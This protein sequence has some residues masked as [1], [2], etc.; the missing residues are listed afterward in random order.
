MNKKLL[1]IILSVLNLVAC[2]SMMSSD[3]KS[4]VTRQ[5]KPA[6][7]AA[8]YN[9]ELGM[10]YLQQGDMQRAKS[11]LLT[12]IQQ[13]PDSAQAQS[14]MGYFL[15]NTGDLRN[16]ENYYAKAVALNPKAG[17]AQNNYGTYLCRRGRYLEADQHFLLAVQDPN[18]LNTA[19]AYE[20]AGLCAMQIPDLTK[21]ANYFNQALQHDPRRSMAWLELGKISFQQQQYTQAQTYFN[22]YMQLTTDPSAD[23]LWLGIRI[24]KQL[25]DNTTAGN[26]ILTLQSKYPN[27]AEYKQVQAMPAAATKKVKRPL[28]F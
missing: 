9:V 14:A 12:A 22:Q 20:N 27:S 11:K 23:A 4:A 1:L 8:D 16:A 18:Y 10:G 15:E 26:L 7:S 6:K 19:G 24:A 28:Y 25:G 13:A 17:N 2:S 5:A 21:A 3:E